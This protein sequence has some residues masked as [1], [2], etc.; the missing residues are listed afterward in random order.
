[1]CLV[2]TS[3]SLEGIFPGGLINRGKKRFDSKYVTRLQITEDSLHGR[4]R[5]GVPTNR[6][7]QLRQ[8]C[9]EIP[10]AQRC[11]QISE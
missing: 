5:K 4:Y 2:E 7:Q 8:R 6:A 11:R 10:L 1:M 3:E 9:Y